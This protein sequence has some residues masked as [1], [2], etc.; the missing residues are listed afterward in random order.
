VGADFAD[1][2]DLPRLRHRPDDVLPGHQQPRGPAGGV[3]LGGAGRHAHP[4]VPPR[5]PPALQRLVPAAAAGVLG[6][7]ARPA[8]RLRP[9]V[10]RRQRTVPADRRGARAPRLAA[11]AP[12]LRLRCVRH[13]RRR[14]PGPARTGRGLAHAAPA[15]VVRA[16]QL[17]PRRARAAA[18]ARCAGG[19]GRRRR[20]AAQHVRGVRRRRAGRARRR[21]AGRARRDAPY[22]HHRQHQPAAGLDPLG[23]DLRQ[24]GQPPHRAAAGRSGGAAGCVRAA[25]G[26]ALPGRVPRARLAAPAD[27]PLA[28]RH[29]RRWPRRRARRHAGP[30]PAG[31][32]D[33][34]CRAGERAGRRGRQR[35]PARSGG[36]RVRA[37]RVQPVA[38]AAQRCARGGARYPRRLADDGLR[39]RG[40]RRRAGR[41]PAARRPPAVRQRRPQPQ[42]R[43]A[44]RQRPA[45]RAAPRRARRA[46]LRLPRLHGAAAA[47]PRHAA[48][49]DALPGAVHDGQRA[50]RR[51]RAA[52]RHA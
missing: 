17:L 27:Q 30:Y 20:R 19:A 14:R 32:R 12:A 44:L 38:P 35:R 9:A 7:A 4:R 22:V 28:R 16:R 26:R 41:V 48:A 23:A 29:R 40:C 13:T 5:R 2:A 37:A 42:R 24:A 50:S 8:Q 36:R 15:V 6:R 31:A 18:A 46:A 10:V 51:D 45:P 21:L 49:G 47:G 34:Y 3:H 39:R 25:V 1:A 43:A 52:Q 11:A 33:Q